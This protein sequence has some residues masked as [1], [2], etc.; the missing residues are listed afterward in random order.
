MR[1]ARARVLNG[2]RRPLRDAVSEGQKKGRAFPY[3]NRALNTQVSQCNSNNRMAD[4]VP[5]CWARAGPGVNISSAGLPVSPGLPPEESPISRMLHYA[6]VGSHSLA[7]SPSRPGRARV[8]LTARQM[9]PPKITKRRAVL[10]TLKR[11]S[12]AGDLL[13]GRVP[14]NQKVNAALRSNK[15]VGARTAKRNED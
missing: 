7:V 8:T 9:H 11:Q 13:R 6:R 3:N 4:E 10:L 14:E 5:S 2:R 12:I 1:R 15:D